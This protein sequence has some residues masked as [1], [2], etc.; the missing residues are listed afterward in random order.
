MRSGLVVAI[1]L[2][3]APLTQAGFVT[4]ASARFQL[5]GHPWYF[6]GDNVYYLGVMAS[7]G[8]G[9]T[10][11][12]DNSVTMSQALGI[13]VWRVWGFCDGHGDCP[14]SLTWQDP[15]GVFNDTNL[16]GL[17][18]VV[19][20][21][22]A[23]G[24]KLEI[25]LQGTYT[26]HGGIPVILGWCGQ[27]PTNRPI[28]FTDT[29]SKTLVKNWITHLLNHTNFYTGVVYKNDPTIFAWE[30]QTEVEFNDDITDPTSTNVAAWLTEMVAHIHSIETNHLITN[31][32]QG[33]DVPAYASLYTHYA[34]P[35]WMLN[36]IKGVSFRKNCAVLD[37]CTA[38]LYPDG[39]SQPDPLNLSTAWITDHQAIAQSLGKP[40]VLGEFG[41]TEGYLGVSL[42]AYIANVFS[43]V[44]AVHLAGA[45]YWQLQCASLCQGAGSDRATQYPPA[46]GVSDAL[47]AGAAAQAAQSIAGTAG[48]GRLRMRY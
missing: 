1:L 28:Y 37:F 41:F 32:E 24:I 22:G 2:I 39:W 6:V 19:Q 33:W 31:G 30:L 7:P 36:G 18:Y 13:T 14:A 45:D 12:V 29:C 8:W 10:A 42:A 35:S 40:V 43:A 17:D 11:A 23:A 47:A 4:V 15:N 34:Y 16:R 46:T 25:A 21:A 38:H 20:K 26:A 27:D 5:D 44:A 9:N 48:A 3:L